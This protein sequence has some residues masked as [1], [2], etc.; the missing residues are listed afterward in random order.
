MDKRRFSLEEFQALFP[1]R[2]RSPE[3]LL[4][5]YRSFQAVFE[6]VDSTAVPELSAEQKAEIFRQSWQARRQDRPRVRI[7]L[8]LFRRPA[9]TFAAGI[10]L[11]CTLMFAA[12]NVRAG[13]SQPR[14]AQPRADVERPTVDRTLIVEHAGDTQVYQGKAVEAMYPQIENPKIVLE[15]TEKSPPKRVL[16]GTV[17]DGGIYVVWNL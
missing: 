10:L 15:K 1:G 2:F 8:D 16:Y 5:E 14:L 7:G 11:G 12:T 6:R 13:W 9:A 4:R 17:N 3:Q